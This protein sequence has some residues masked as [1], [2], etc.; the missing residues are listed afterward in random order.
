MVRHLA[1]S[2][3]RSEQRRERR[4]RTAARPEGLPSVAEGVARLELQRRVV[5]AVLALDEPYRS[6]V[7]HR[8]F[9]GLAP[10]EIARRLG[11][12]LETVR[13]R[14]RR[15]LERLRARLDTAYGGD[16]RSLVHGTS[17]V[18][19]RPAEGHGGFFGRDA[20][21]VRQDQDRGR[22]PCFSSRAPSCL[23][24]VWEA[25]ARRTLVPRTVA[26]VNGA[27]LD[28]GGR[29][30]TRRVTAL[31]APV[32]FATIDRDRDVHGVVVDDAGGPVPGARVRIVR[33][34]GMGILGKSE[35]Q[36]REE[37]GPEGRTAADGTFALR[38]K[39]GEEV[40]LRVNAHGFV[41]LQRRW[42]PAGGKL[43][44]E[45]RR[46]V[47]VLVRALGPTGEPLAGVRIGAFKDHRSPA[48][49]AA[50]LYSHTGGDDERRG[51]VQ[52]R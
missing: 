12:P 1:L 26:A 22:L 47:R 14:Q 5:E 28:T 24:L 34:P 46:G 8:F 21:H 29:R 18:G 43:R 27:G 10:K 44:V 9:Y 40:D 11:V 25:T 49:E 36:V 37:E 51:P 45:L 50:G 31:P 39:R 48:M 16:G 52:V 3:A 13:T 23:S 15:A 20:C 41:P 6:V 38:V 19:C 17:R 32:D 35:N 33:Y 42:C 4:E 7:V 2:R 30:G